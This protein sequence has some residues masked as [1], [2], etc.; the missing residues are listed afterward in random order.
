M[1]PDRL[2]DED[3]RGATDLSLGNNGIRWPLDRDLDDASYYLG[4]GQKQ[5][6]RRFTHDSNHIPELTAIRPCRE[7][8]QP[9]AEKLRESQERYRWRLTL[10]TKPSAMNSI[11]VDDPP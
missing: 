5:E 10:S 8:A 7:G 9:L 3:E 1:A 6:Q 11:I 4:N 2:G